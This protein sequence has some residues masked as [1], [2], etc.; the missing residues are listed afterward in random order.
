VLRHPPRQTRTMFR[1]TNQLAYT[2]RVEEPNPVYARYLQQ[3]I[4]GIDGEIRVCLQY[5]FQGVNFRGP[6]R[7]KDMLM[8]TATEEIGHIEMLAT[9]VALN[10]ETASADLKEEAAAASPVVG[11]IMGGQNPQHVISAGLGA[12]AVDS[13]GNP[14]NGSWVVDSGN[15][16]VNM[17]AN[18]AAEGA[19]R[20]LATRLWE[21]TDDPGM[22]DMWSYL[23]ARDTMHQNQWQAVL[24]E[25]KDMGLPA[26]NDFPQEQEHQEFSYTFLEHSDAKVPDD[27]RWVSGPSVDGNGKFSRREA[28]PFGPLAG[29]DGN[30][31]ELAPPEARPEL[32]NTIIQAKGGAMRQLKDAITP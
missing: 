20:A 26:P 12:M 2:V 32:H 19:G 24:E 8:N 17:N 11:A 16:A 28:E 22:K 29:Q 21:I 7:Y 18:V 6:A 9:A 3:A 30:R 23:I 31:Q 13:N 25:I 5:L 4:G 14:F 10:L 15:L 27:A 1:H